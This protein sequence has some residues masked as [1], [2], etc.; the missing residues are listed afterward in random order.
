MGINVDLWKSSTKSIFNGVLLYSIC[1][2]VA[3]ALGGIMAL[4]ATAGLAAGSAGALGAA[5][6]L[7]VLSF[8]ALVLVLVGYIIYFLGVGKFRDAVDEA[9]KPYAQKIYMGIIV[10][11]A[12]VVISLIPVIGV[13]G[14]IANIVA[15]ILMFLAYQGLKE[16]Q[17]F[18][19]LARKGANVLYW[20]MIISVISVVLGWIPVLNVIGGI[21]QIASFIMIFI[22]WG[23]IKNAQV[24]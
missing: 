3:A 14:K 10:I 9:D 22:G 19:E 15:F 18:P 23:K 2:I 17:T 6:G 20:A 4:T 11:I 12:G 16:S 21:C 24:E 13:I 7:G 5:A 8:I 1:G